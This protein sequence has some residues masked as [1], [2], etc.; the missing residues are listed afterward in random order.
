MTADALSRPQCVTV[1]MVGSAI[2]LLER[3]VTANRAARDDAATSA[4]RTATKRHDIVIDR[5]IS[6]RP[7]LHSPYPELSVSMSTR[8]DLLLVGFAPDSPV[9]VDLEVEDI[10]PL[11]D[12]ERLAGDHYASAE[13]ELISSAQT[14]AYARDMFLRLWVAKEAALKLSGRG[15]FD[16]LREPNFAPVLGKLTVDGVIIFV[17]ATRSLPSFRIATRRLEDVAT[18]AGAIYCALAVSED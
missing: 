15:V 3:G 16:G 17:P 10:V 12:I 14:P 8:S 11:A 6:G 1:L 2:A 5:R 4:L 13:A 7:K 18:P 9:G